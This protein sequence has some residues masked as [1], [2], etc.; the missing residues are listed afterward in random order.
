MCDVLLNELIHFYCSFTIQLERLAIFQK[1]LHRYQS[2]AASTKTRTGIVKD[3][4]FLSESR[5]NRAKTVDAEGSSEFELRCE[6]DKSLSSIQDQYATPQ[7]IHNVA[8]KWAIHLSSSLISKSKSTTRNPLWN[9]GTLLGGFI[10]D[11]IKFC[12]DGIQ[13]GSQSGHNKAISWDSIGGLH[14]AKDELT[15]ILEWPIKVI[16]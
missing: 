2:S 3:L 6:L 15:K 9:D 10:Q 12:E 13:K 1:C 4:L 8:R 7:L 14:G 5:N 11:E 16:L